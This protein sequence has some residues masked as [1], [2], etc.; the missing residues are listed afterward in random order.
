V[1]QSAKFEF[2]INRRTAKA[3][4]LGIPVMLRV[5]ATELIGS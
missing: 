1:Q 4:G 5:S 3:P 2:V